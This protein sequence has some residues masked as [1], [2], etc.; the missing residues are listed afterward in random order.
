MGDQLSPDIATL[1]DG[2]RDRDIVLMAE[3]RDETTYV[4]HHPK[5]IAFILSAMRHHAAALEEDGWC[6]DYVA[7]EADGNS[8]S[9]A[10]EVHRALERYDCT[11]VRVTEP[12]EWRVRRQFEEL[13]DTLPVPLAILPD[14]RFLCSREEFA[15]WAKDRKELRMEHFYRW[16]RRRT[17]LLMNEDEPCGGQ[18]NFDADNR[19]RPGD[20]LAPEP[21][22]R[23]PPDATTKEVLD[24]VNRHFAGNFGTLEPFWFAVTASDAQAA[25]AQFVDT[26]LPSFGAYQDAMLNNEPFLFHAVIALYLNVGLLDPLTV[27]RTVE[28]AY[29]DGDIPINA[30]EGFIRQIIGWRE[31]VRGLYWL[32]MPDYAEMNA[33]GHSRPLPDF[34]WSGETDLT[35]LSTCIVQTREEAYAHHIQ[36]LMVTGNFALLTGVDPRLVHEWYLAV[37]A[38]AFEWVELPN[39]L[40]MSQ[41][42]DGGRLGS[43]P[44]AAGGNYINRMSDY[45]G[46]CHYDVKQKTGPE[47]CP[48]NYLY[49]NFLD[50]HEA[51]LSDNPRLAMPYRNWRKRSKADR[52]AVR[53]SADQFLS[54]LFDAD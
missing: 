5:K 23:Q 54:S 30:A 33:L 2:V 16:M 25:F 14:D 18:W 17:G 13:A 41:F 36:R 37:Y 42:A 28:A 38:D 47:A 44:Y 31:Y 11:E 45:C 46:A 34:Y 24:L 8:G 39:T 52:T 10:G 51:T 35:C 19:K 53:E 1:R 26:S 4:P 49:W 40:G 15:D 20:G 9:F 22:R 3:V 43:K 6:V 27:C 29:R 12:G 21:P 32:E 48:F 50:R 7:L